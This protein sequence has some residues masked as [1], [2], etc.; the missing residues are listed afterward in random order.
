MTV[1]MPA[2]MADIGS[3]A[4]NMLCWC[5]SDR[6]ERG[7]RCFEQGTLSWSIT[8]RYLSTEDGRARLSQ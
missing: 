1:L 7:L 5:T 2:G 4:C 8:Y 3:M 6:V